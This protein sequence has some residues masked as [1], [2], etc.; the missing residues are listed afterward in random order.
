MPQNEKWNLGS[1][2]LEFVKSYKYLW[3]WIYHN[4]RFNIHLQEKQN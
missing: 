3:V 4:G 2:E 1:I